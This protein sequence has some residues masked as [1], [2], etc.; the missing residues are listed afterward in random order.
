MKKLKCDFCSEEHEPLVCIPCKTF[1][2]KHMVGNFPM[3]SITDWWACPA[4]FDIIQKGDHEGLN[5]RSKQSYIQ[6]Y[7]KDAWDDRIDPYLHEFHKQFW[8][9]KQ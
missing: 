5:Q 2:V 3:T 7:G 9:N 8:E 6:K 4:C 1:D